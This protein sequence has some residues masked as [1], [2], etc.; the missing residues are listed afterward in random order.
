MLA[1]P[2]VEHIPG[3]RLIVVDR[4][5]VLA[6]RTH[7]LSARRACAAVKLSRAAYYRPVRNRDDRDGRVIEALN[8]LVAARSRWSFW[9]CFDRLRLDGRPLFDGLGQ[10]RQI[11]Y[12]WPHTYN[13]N[14]PHDALAVSLRPSSGDGSE[15]LENSSF[16]LS[17]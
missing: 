4:P 6:K 10:V 8:E 1:V 9:K 17:T 16:E 14:R 3:T 12:R 11:T 7:A 5:V 2:W 13:E 15:W